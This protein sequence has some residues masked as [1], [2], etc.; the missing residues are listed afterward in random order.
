LLDT[1]ALVGH[2]VPAGS[3]YAL[4]AE[5]RQVLF[6]YGMFT[7][8][9]NRLRDFARPDRIFDAGAR[10]CCTRLAAPSLTCRRCPA[11]TTSG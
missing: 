6:P 5:H 3:V 7:G 4:L 1:A 8:W 10:S 11:R 9:R 2:L